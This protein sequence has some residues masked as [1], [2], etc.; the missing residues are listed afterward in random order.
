MREM[1][2]K[3]GNEFYLYLETEASA[4]LALILHLEPGA[5]ARQGFTKITGNSA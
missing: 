5:E 4:Y 2:E 3:I 1:A